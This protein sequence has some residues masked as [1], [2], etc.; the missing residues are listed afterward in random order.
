MRFRKWT[1]NLE[2]ETEQKAVETKLE[3]MRVEYRQNDRIEKTY[4]TKAM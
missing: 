1:N 3:C 4:E 2:E